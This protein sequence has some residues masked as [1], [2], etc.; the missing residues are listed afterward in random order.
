MEHTTPPPVIRREE[1]AIRI[2]LVV[3]SITTLVLVGLLIRDYRITHHPRLSRTHAPLTVNDVNVI[4]SWMT[5]D[6]INR[7][8]A[9]SPNILKAA[10]SITDPRYPRMP[11]GKLLQNTKDALRAY[12]TSTK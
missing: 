9:L 1:R 2:A 5:F 7:I 4:Q 11:V 10:L 3:L 8:F 12:L 6:Y